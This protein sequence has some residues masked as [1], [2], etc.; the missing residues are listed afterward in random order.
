[1]KKILVVIVIGIVFLGCAS[2]NPDFF[3]DETYREKVLVSAKNYKDLIK[4]YR[5]KLEKKDTPEIRIKLA[6]Y[7]YEVQDYNSVFYYLQPLVET[8]KSTQAL[9]LYAKALES[10]G[11][12]KEALQKLDE[13][14]LLDVNISEA[15]N[16]K[17]IIYCSEKNFD[18]AKQN[19]L[20]AKELFLSDSIINTNLAMMEILQQNYP[21]AIN[22]LMPLY[23]RGYKDSK[24]INNLVFA[25]TKANKT[26]LALEIVQKENLSKSP[27]NFIR[28]LQKIKATNL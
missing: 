23:T 28:N 27:R 5:E 24:I 22:Y 11:K 13:L 4:M 6:Q 12:Y 26:S 3:G 9:L 20:R 19:F 18:L 2:K 15:Y 17:G 10:I 8:K 16:L 14:T 7:Y 1:M 21:E 25:L